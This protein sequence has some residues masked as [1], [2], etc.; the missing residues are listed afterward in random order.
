MRQG[1]CEEIVG[2]LLISSKVNKAKIKNELDDLETGDPFF[3]PNTDTEGGKE[4]IPV[5]HHM[6]TQVQAD[7]HP[8]NRGGSNKLGVAKQSSSTMVVSVEESQLL[9]F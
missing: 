5:H 8:Q 9:L 3:P 4:V 1:V 6:D 2:D 7:W